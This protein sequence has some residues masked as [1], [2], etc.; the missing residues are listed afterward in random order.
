MY[1]PGT[2]ITKHDAIQHIISGLRRFVYLK[3][4][5]TAELFIKCFQCKKIAASCTRANLCKIIYKYYI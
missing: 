5:E 2:P 1:V 4:E 3:K